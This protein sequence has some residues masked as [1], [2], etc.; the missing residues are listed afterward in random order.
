M[1]TVASAAGLAATM[2]LRRRQ[3][4]A[5]QDGPAVGSEEVKAYTA[6][7]ADYLVWIDRMEGSSPTREDFR[8]N[9]LNLRRLAYS[10]FTK[11]AGAKFDVLFDTEKLAA[12]LTTKDVSAT[13][14]D[15]L[16]STGNIMTGSPFAP[17]SGCEQAPVDTSHLFVG[18][19]F[20]FNRRE[21]NTWRMVA[22]M[23]DPSLGEVFDTGIQGLVTW[24]GDL[25]SWFVEWNSDR[26]KAEAAGTPWTAAQSEEHR[27]SVLVRKMSLQDL[28]SD[29]DAQVLAAH[30][31]RTPSIVSVG[32]L[33]RGY[34]LDPPVTGTPHVSTRF[35]SF[36]KAAQPPIP[37]TESGST[38]TL[39]AKAAES[40]AQAVTLVAWLF[41]L[42]ERRGTKGIKGAAESAL[43][44][45]T[46]QATV[47]RSMA[48]DFVAF[49]TAALTGGAPS[50]PSD[51]LYALQTRY[52]GFY[53]QP[54]D[55]D[56]TKKYGGA[57]RAGDPGG[58]VEKLHDDLVLVGF[59]CL[60]AKGTAAYREYGRSTQW[61]VRHLQGYAGTEGVAGVLEPL[62][63]PH[64]ADPLFHLHNPRRYWGPVHGLLDPETATVLARWVTDTTARRGTAPGVTERV[65]VADR[66]HCPVVMES[67][68]WNTASAPTTFV[69]DRIWLRDDPAVGDA[70]WA[71]DASM[72]Y[73]I[74]ANRVVAPVD[75]VAAGS[76]ASVPGMGQGPISRSYKPNSLWSPD[77]RVDPMR[78]T[79]A[80]IDPA[81]DVARAS[82]YRV[83]AAVAAL[84]CGSYLDSMNGWDS[85]VVSLGVAHWT[86]WPAHHTGE[87][88]ALLAYLRMKYPA[89]Y[90]RYLGVFGVYPAYPWPQTWPNPMWD[91]GARKYVCAPVLYGLPGSGGSY[92][93][94]VAVPVTEA[95][96]FER[97]R[98]WHWWYR[99]LMMC[100][101]SPELWRCEWDMARTRI[102]DILRTPWA[103]AV[104]TNVPTVPDGNG[105]TRPATFGDVFTCE[106]A[107]ALVYRYHVNF[108]N[109][110]ISSGRAGT[111]MA[112]TIAGANLA[113]MDTTTWGD[114]EQT[115]IVAAL[116]VNYPASFA[117][118]GTAWD[119]WSDPA[120]GADGS[121]REGHGS[122][123][124]DDTDLP[125]P[126][127]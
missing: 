69:K 10:R 68:K 45:V 65:K 72:Y 16:Y 2:R 77:T 15:R 7:L 8:R 25:A 55:S 121:L 47:I 86:I 42:I 22:T 88:F 63:G 67:W 98:D 54:G 82:T 31:V 85:A 49:L 33:L 35:A 78:L 100:R 71:R 6:R 104:G 20:A 56:A 41:L 17:Y 103:K 14:L 62:T 90:E 1:G 28:L 76:M 40:V 61:A 24:V 26:I 122:F 30:A 60:P 84:E 44:D 66:L 70:V 39:D 52:G 46:A 95:D 5:W 110:I 92:Q 74:P 91:P 112:D 34:Y 48:D 21:F 23:L 111:K 81:T 50:W 19:D 80:A 73:D 93:R 58:H 83:V 36:V 115:K 51:H 9:V 43:A 127:S 125:L 94:D 87:L 114:A 59:T 126:M 119:H 124:L 4:E 12:P 123:V 105:G 106:H 64:A 37:H 3:R 118:V 102:R 96:D 29:L 79:G 27:K 109:P 120:L 18:I 57:V 97:F 117:D 53:L 113:S 116:R 89:V 108:P 11:G 101:N 107:V 75:G 13:T 32:A 38:V 99:F